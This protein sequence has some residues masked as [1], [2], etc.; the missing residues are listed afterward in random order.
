M[1]YFESICKTLLED[2][3]YWVRQSYK[4]ELSKEQKR[5]LGK[6]SLPRPEIDL[7]AF[8]HHCCHL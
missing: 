7:I 1:D 5:K 4:V 8:N 3:G 6:P 2:E